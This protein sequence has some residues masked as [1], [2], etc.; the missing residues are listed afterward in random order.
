MALEKSEGERI[1]YIPD[2]P[3]AIAGAESRGGRVL[4]RV[5]QKTE[6]GRVVYSWASTSGM[7]DG[8]VLVAVAFQ[9]VNVA[10]HGIAHS[11]KG[12]EILVRNVRSLKKT[13]KGAATRKRSTNKATSALQGSKDEALPPASGKA[14]VSSRKRSAAKRASPG[15]K[16]PPN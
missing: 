3:A 5:V 14:V 10:L 16:T 11:T 12:V 15:D 4:G 9:A 13:L 8:I 6:N 2:T 1:E 7:A